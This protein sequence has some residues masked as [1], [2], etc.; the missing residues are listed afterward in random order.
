MNQPPYDHKMTSRHT[1]MIEGTEKK[2][3]WVPKTLQNRNVSFL[4]LIL[5][6]H[7]MRKLNNVFLHNVL[8]QYFSGLCN[9]QPNTDSDTAEA[10]DSKI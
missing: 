7:Y 9:T 3:I 10:S 2:C 8:S 5:P 6:F 1:R 4:L